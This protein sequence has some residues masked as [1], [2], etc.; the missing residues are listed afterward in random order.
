[1]NVEQERRMIAAVFDSMSER[2]R[3]MRMSRSQLF[4][5]HDARNEAA[6]SILLVAEAFG[7]DHCVL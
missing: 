4:E 2:R 5:S 7:S 3:K 6:K 1:M